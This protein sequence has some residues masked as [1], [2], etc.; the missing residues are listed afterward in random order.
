MA[1][2]EAELESVHRVIN[3]N[4]ERNDSLVVFILIERETVVDEEARVALAT[5]RIK[6]LVTTAREKQQR[7]RKRE[8]IR[9][10]RERRRKQEK[11]FEGRRKEK[12]KE[13]RER[14][15]VASS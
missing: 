6:N 11:E 13:E 8:K 12:R 9:Q 14:E 3:R 5:V 15:T 1:T 2:E 10:E 4:G 7:K